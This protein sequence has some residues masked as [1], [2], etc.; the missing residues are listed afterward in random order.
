[1][2]PPYRLRH[3]TTRALLLPQIPIPPQALVS[4]NS[5]LFELDVVVR[6]VAA[7]A[8]EAPRSSS[9]HFSD[10]LRR[11]LLPSQRHL[12][13]LLQRPLSRAAR[14]Q[15]TVAFRLA[16]AI[17]AAASYGFWAW[18]HQAPSVQALPAFTIA[19]IGTARHQGANLT[20]ALLRGRVYRLVKRPHIRSL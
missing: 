19:Y 8:L 11:D 13:E 12:I 17:T 20:A 10:E 4:T 6:L 18:P 1:M 9:A 15:L 3:S 5:L 2:Y 7:S 16:L 14:L